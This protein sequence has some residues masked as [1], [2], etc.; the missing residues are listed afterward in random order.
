LGEPFGKE[1]TLFNLDDLFDQGN[2]AIQA[3]FVKSFGQ[4]KMPM[5]VEAMSVS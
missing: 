4:Y 5:G 3:K 2:G 1:L